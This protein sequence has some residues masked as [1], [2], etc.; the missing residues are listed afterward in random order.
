MQLTDD[1]KTLAELMFIDLSPERKV[2]FINLQ[3][4]YKEK[5]YAKAHSAINCLGK[6][7]KIMVS[8]GQVKK[9][10]DERFLFNKVVNIIKEFLKGVK[11][12][13]AELFPV[14]ELA[15]RILGD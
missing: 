9:E 6:M 11:T 3:Q 1:V 7:N 10:V 15:H 2:D 13:K 5:W 4:V 8:P 12:T 14:E